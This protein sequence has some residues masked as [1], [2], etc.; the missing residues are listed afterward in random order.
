MKRVVLTAVLAMA[1]VAGAFAQ[2]YMV[3]N[4][5][6]VFK[7]IDAYNEAI[8]ELDRL[9]ESYQKQVDAKFAEV[10]RL[11]N[12]YVARK[13]TYSVTGQQE[14][15][16]TILSREEEATKF[17]ESL[18]GTDGTLMKERVKLIQPIQERVFAAIEKYAS[19]NGFDLVLDVAS[20]PNV[21]Y[22]SAAA[23]RTEAVIG[24]LNE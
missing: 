24:V 11:Y 1:A 8:T 20:N 10:E 5:E 3:V 21:L 18:F 17:Q 13:S 9:A 2:N 12:N 19:A 7:S 16:N 6:K 15:E 22:Y 4:S 23:D 14:M